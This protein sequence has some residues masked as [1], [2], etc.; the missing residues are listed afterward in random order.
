MVQRPAIVAALALTAG[1]FTSS[2][3]ADH[4]GVL[5]F[6]ALAVAAV[7]LGV[8][9]FVDRSDSLLRG[10]PAYVVAAAAL[11]FLAGSARFTQSSASWHQFIE[12][13]SVR[14]SL[15]GVVTGPVYRD[16][17]ATRFVVTLTGVQSVEGQRISVRLVREAHTDT[18][19][20]VRTGV[21]SVILIGPLS[22]WQPLRNPADVDYAASAWA[23]GIAGSVTISDASAIR[24]V[25]RSPSAIDKIRM[26]VRRS[27]IAHTDV[28]A[29]PVLNALLLGDRSQLDSDARDALARTGLMHL[30]A[31]SGLHVLLIGLAAYRLLKSILVR[32]SI[33]WY[34]MEWIRVPL[35]VALLVLYA[36][37]TGMQPSSVR[38]VIMGSLFLAG[39]LAKRRPDSLNLLGVAAI[40][41]L[42]H[43]PEQ[44]YAVG[45]QLSFSAVAAILVVAG[46][47]RDHLPGGTRMA[48]LRSSLATSVAASV[49]TAPALMSAFGYTPVAGLV[50]NVVAIPL[51]AVALTSGVLCIITAGILPAIAG[52]F[53][54]TAS[55]AVNMLT[56]G[57]VALA[58]YAPI[59]SDSLLHSHTAQVLSATTLLSIVVHLS[60]TQDR[61]R[62]TVALTG[63]AAF[64][65][66]YGSLASVVDQLSSP[67]S[68]DV[69]FLDVGQG[70]AAII[71]TPSGRF[72]VIDTGPPGMRSS[73]AKRSVVP[74]LR[75]LGAKGVDALIVSHPHADHD[76][77]V[78]DIVE[79]FKVSHL[80]VEGR[81]YGDQRGGRVYTSLYAGDHFALDEVRFDV[82]GP[83]HPTMRDSRHVSVNDASTV[84]RLTFGTTCIVFMGDAEEGA[85]QF[86]VRSQTWLRCEIIKVGH[87]G[88]RT[89]S[90]SAFVDATRIN[91]NAPGRAVPSMTP[92]AV[93][94]AGADN[95]FGHPH[96]SVVNR[97][98]RSGREVRLTTGGAVWI[99]IEPT[100]FHTHDW[101]A[102]G[103]YRES[104]TSRG[105]Q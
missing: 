72:V 60:R 3:F 68:I 66:A 95:R 5:R 69:I 91:P 103:K 26:Y 104:H 90:T 96:A 19:T 57:S 35:T 71:K 47:I 46:P 77:G 88:S 86:L 55:L 30:L 43:R 75:R 89:S 101:R 79:A 31:V 15:Q 45:F 9:L 17:F 82:L 10:R 85:E 52:Y 98:S 78:P 56:H 62:Y 73:A 92:L 1:V 83:P 50:L 28:T 65:I 24:A 2:N 64:I 61:W 12:S 59:L 25:D 67:A 21:S 48:A 84:I 22:L 23:R 7:A 80:F 58:D 100:S 39:T 29:Q 54:R 41:G 99:R 13:A 81:M 34:T 63:T 20:P 27:I 33:S 105:L 40:V 49:G 16:S 93:I 32:F 94:S 97:W 38:A 8:G 14:D 36:A 102:A 76:G 4:A 51:T 44:L 53:G 6:L 70:D 42:V 18:S 74:L 87:H 37:L 11:F